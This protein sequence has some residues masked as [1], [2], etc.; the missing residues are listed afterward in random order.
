MVQL[1]YSTIIVAIPDTL[2]ETSLSGGLADPFKYRRRRCG[3]A[4]RGQPTD[5]YLN[6]CANLEVVTEERDLGVLFDNRLD[7]DKHI[8]TIVGKAIC[9]LC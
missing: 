3:V 2:R 8:R 5:R 6:Y 4:E 9:I 7:F 1:F